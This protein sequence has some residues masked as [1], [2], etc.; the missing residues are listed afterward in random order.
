MI[1]AEMLEGGG[2]ERSVELAAG[3]ERSFALYRSL[4]GSFRSGTIAELLENTTRLMLLG[5]GEQRLREL[6]AGYVAETLP[7]VYPTDEALQFRDYLRANPVAVAGLEDVLGFEAGLI[8]AAA[9]S[10]VVQVALGR[11]IDALLGDIAAGRLPE[12]GADGEEMV[13][14]IGVDPVP[15]VRV[16]EAEGGG[17][18]LRA[19]KGGQVGRRF[20]L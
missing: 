5:L 3:D 7:R 6:M 10:C 14:E 20:V 19:G 4:A 17:L 11:N 2:A 8:E 12:A 15:F 16:V 18:G 13:L 1:A 9:N